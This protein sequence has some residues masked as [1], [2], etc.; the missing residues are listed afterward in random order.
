MRSNGQFM[1]PEIRPDLGQKGYFVLESVFS[2]TEISDLIQRLP[3]LGDRAGTRSLLEETVGQ[4]CAADERV[5]DLVR[6]ALGTVAK[7]VR[8]ILFDKTPDT[9]WTLGWHQD[10]KI[11]V[12][13]RRDVA[14]YSAWS[15]K[16][17]VVHCRPPVHVLENMIAVRIHL[18]D[19]GES[20]GP[21]QVI[22]ASHRQGFC[23][24]VN[25]AEAVQLTCKAGDVIL[26]KPLTLHASSKSDSPSH[27]RVIHIEFCAVQLNGGL[28]WAVD[29]L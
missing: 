2:H 16:E 27:R 13:E 29:G 8:G 5:I 7:P 19:C 6:S 18:D 23:D 11:A 28:C 24:V 14:G 15:V 26:I 12:L 10:T 17:G 20:N 1:P 9:N 25:E 4:E 3:A 21:L 22:P